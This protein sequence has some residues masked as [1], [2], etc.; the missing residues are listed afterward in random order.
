MSAKTHDELFLGI[1]VSKDRLDVCVHPV[2][3][4]RSFRNS[5][6]GFKE[7]LVFV[8]PWNPVLTVLESTGGLEALVALTLAANAHPTVVV[9]PRQVRDFAKATG[10]LAKT[11]A[12]DCAVIAHFAAAVRPEVRPLKNAEERALNDLKTRRRQLVEMLTME[13]NR[14]V[15][16]PPSI[17]E[18]IKDHV[19]WLNERLGD[20][21]D[22]IRRFIRT[23]PMWKE[24][25]ARYQSVKGVGPTM[26]LTLLT[27]LP[28]LG[29]LNRKQVAALAGVAP[30]NRD[31]GRLRGK[32]SVWGG[33]AHLRATLYMSTLVATRY[34]PVIRRF[35]QRLLDAGKCK[36]VALTACMR[37]LL[38]ILNAMAKNE[39]KWE[40]PAT[41]SA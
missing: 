21:D 38:T 1:D 30:L 35:Y 12:I 32:R 20:H 16:A 15:S 10:K 23:S 31:S 27:D 28:E 40:D 25:D 26:S 39:T 22:E 5:D 9:N 36:K 6:E 33:R 11:D 34:N 29:T 7:L 4:R 18:D 13:K 19:T 3:E 24:K 41:I 14:L 37:K 17:Y 8:E 2:G